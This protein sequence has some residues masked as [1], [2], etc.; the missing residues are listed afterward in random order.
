M[1]VL[2][3]GTNSIPHLREK[4]KR[5]GKTQASF[6]WFFYFAYR[7]CL[8][9]EE[10]PDFRLRR[11]GFKENEPQPRICVSEYKRLQ[12]VFVSSGIIWQRNPPVLGIKAAFRSFKTDSSMAAGICCKKGFYVML[13]SLS[14]AV[15]R[16]RYSTKARRKFAPA[17]MKSKGRPAMAQARAMEAPPKGR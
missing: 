1:C 14:K 8:K 3:S 12:N 15:R 17:W 11:G 6:L 7:A 4:V 13:G 10:A 16:G 2:M 5:L 9:T